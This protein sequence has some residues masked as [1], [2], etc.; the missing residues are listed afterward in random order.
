MLVHPMTSTNVATGARTMQ[1]P[2]VRLE[3]L[4]YFLLSLL[5]VA[6]VADPLSVEVAVPHDRGKK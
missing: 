2:H 3:A 1:S 4:L 5:P 6:V